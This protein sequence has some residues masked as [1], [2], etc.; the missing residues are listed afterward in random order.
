MTSWNGLRIAI[1]GGTSGLGRA[2][3]LA[4]IG[5]GARVATFARDEGR[6]AELRAIAPGIAA[7]EGDV[8]NK[9]HVYPLAMRIVAAL[10]GVDVLV[11][12][13]SSLGPSPL[14]LL[15]DTD[16]EDLE[17]AL[18]TN[19]VGPLRWT[20]A[21][22]GPLAESA[23]SGQGGVVITV[24]SDAA[25]EVYPRWGAYGASKAALLHMT[26]VFDAELAR[27]GLRFDSFDPGDMDTPLH[28][29]AVPDANREAL[30]RPERSAERL[31]ARIEQLLARR[32][33]EARP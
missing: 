19:V 26:R 24:S 25:V 30:G 9:E 17:L 18:Q 6:L 31:I 27:A 1:T 23:R 4:A 14:R 12:N 22:L 5:K 21:L 8:A 7:F 11:H 2:F 10:S 28:L 33:I 32:A 29:A 16:C 13:A 20:K 3:A 15:A